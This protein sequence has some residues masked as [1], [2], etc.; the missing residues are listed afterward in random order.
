MTHEPSLLVRNQL[1]LLQCAFFKWTGTPTVNNPI[2][3]VLVGS[4]TNFNP[5]VS[6]NSIQLP[7]GEYL[8]RGYISITRN[9]TSSNLVFQWRQV[10]GGLIGEN[11]ATNRELSPGTV[12][13]SLDSVDAHL[14]LS[15]PGSVQLEMTQVDSGIV[16]DTSN[17]HAII[18]R[19][20]E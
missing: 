13:L 17:S 19:L 2:T 3:P 8:L 6:S 1:G 16:L 4:S 12:L 20:P 5:T 11:G 7:A 9:T 10:G 15:S 14:T 18:W